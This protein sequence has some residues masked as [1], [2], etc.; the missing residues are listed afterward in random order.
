[1][2]SRVPV[3][4][5]KDGVQ[6]FGARAKIRGDVESL[7]GSDID[8]LLRPEDVSAKV[9]SDGLG[10]VNHRSFLGAT[11]RLGVELGGVSVK[12]DVRSSDAEL[13]ELGTRVDLALSSRDVLV[14]ERKKDA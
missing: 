2:S 5:L 11:T 10:I 7:A 4:R 14:T 13:F 3:T 8:A 9:A 6:L 1:V 12:V